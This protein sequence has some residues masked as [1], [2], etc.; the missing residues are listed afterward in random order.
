MN[1]T[2]NQLAFILDAIDPY[3]GYG[4]YTT[5]D[6][7]YHLT[8]DEIDE[9]IS[10]LDNKLNPRPDPVPE[11][12][13]IWQSKNTPRLMLKV[14]SYPYCKITYSYEEYERKGTHRTLPNYDGEPV[15]QI[16]TYNIDPFIIVS[17][18]MV[19]SHKD[20]HY[21]GKKSQIHYRGFHHSYKK[22]HTPTME[23]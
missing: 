21:I 11:I 7:K 6:G 3:E 15:Q 14:E 8:S 18:V 1:F 12:G 10:V 5:Q 19:S 13:S 22:I 17:Y 20:Q 9:L 16:I 2:K 4:D 23:L